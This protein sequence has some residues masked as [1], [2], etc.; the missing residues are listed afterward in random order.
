MI[1][2]IIKMGIPYYFYHLT[3]KYKDIIVD[4]LPEIIDNYFIDFNGV[5]HTECAKLMNGDEKFSEE[6]LIEKL[7]IKINNYNDNYKP[8]KLIICIDGVAPL[9]KIIQQRKRRY[10]TFYKYKIDKIDNKWDTNAISPGTKFMN[11]LNDY[12]KKIMKNLL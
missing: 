1:F 7:F 2:K 3:K 10:L 12:L 4:D 11:K 8:S 6:L 5:I 9:A